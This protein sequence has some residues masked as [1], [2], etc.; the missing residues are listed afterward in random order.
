MAATKKELYEKLQEG[1]PPIHNLYKKTADHDTSINVNNTE[2][3]ISSVGGGALTVLG[4]KKGGWCGVFACAFRRW[5][6]PSRIDR[7]LLS[8]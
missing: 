1:T 8:L 5:F 3:M 7:T 2:R 6:I 4:I